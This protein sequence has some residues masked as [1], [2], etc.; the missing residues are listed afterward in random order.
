LGAATVHTVNGN[1]QIAG[2]KKQ[3]CF[4]RGIAHEGH[5]KHEMPLE[6]NGL[7]KLSE[8]CGELVQAAM[9]RVAFDGEG[10]IH[11]DGSNLKERLADEIAD[12][13]AACTVVQKY[14]GLDHVRIGART[15]KK[16]A[17]FNYWHEGGKETS[18]PKITCVWCNGEGA[19]EDLDCDYCG[20]SGLVEQT[21]TPDMNVEIQEE[22]VS[23]LWDFGRLTGASQAS[24]SNAILGTLPRILEQYGLKVA[25]VQ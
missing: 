18:L 20:G 22:I 3:V 23:V 9:K 1:R 14:H 5:E 8:E 6:H 7:I 12:V 13:L 16:V 19:G 21:F 17:L 2:G 15:L 24:I 4:N 11:W 10:D 25:D